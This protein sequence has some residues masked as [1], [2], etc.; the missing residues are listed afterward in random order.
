MPKLYD[1]HSIPFEYELGGVQSLATFAALES[2]DDTAV[3][4]GGIVFVE[5]F[6][7][8]FQKVVG[9]VPVSDD[10]TVAPTHSGDGGWYRLVLASPTWRTQAA[11]Y[12]AFTTGSDEAAGSIAAPLK[13]FAEFQRRL[14]LLSQDTT[15]TFTENTT[16]VVTGHFGAVSGSDVLSLTLQG[17]PDILET[18]TVNVVN[19][20]N[21]ASATNLPGTLTALDGALAAIDWTTLGDGSTKLFVEVTGG[22]NAGFSTPVVGDSGGTTA[23]TADWTLDDT[24]GVAANADPIRVLA[25]RTVPSVKIAAENILVTC[26][27]FHLT[28]QT[29]FSRVVSTQLLWNGVSL[30]TARF[31]SC[32]FDGAIDANGGWICKL[33]SCILD[34]D[35][36]SFS[37]LGGAG[38]LRLIGCG[39]DGDL[40]LT[41]GVTVLFDGTVVVVGSIS[42]S[43]TENHDS[44]NAR[45]QLIVGSQGL[46]IFGVALSTTGLRVSGGD[47]RLNGPLYGKTHLVGL[48]ASLGAVISVKSTLSPAT[49]LTLTGTTELSLSVPN[50]IVA[51]NVVPVVA[52]VPVGSAAFTTWA[53]WAT[54]NRQAINFG[55]M[56][57][58]SGL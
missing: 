41:T 39:I 26:K 56:T 25:A 55:D 40:G 52:G 19:A 34:V 42:L 54:V 21:P 2:F 24:F 36:G 13:T 44:L 57:R 28:D 17:D 5:T 35:A 16:E 11:W 14:P 9:A 10:A 31:L 32:R 6:R 37:I 3:A 4:N 47:V 29:D 33:Q 51:G 30:D 46:G 15:V 43:G 7:D 50:G 20:P 53:N 23:Y 12:V 22:A 38:S 45:P 1:L 58:I 18:G 27:Y 48:S 49:T 8:Y